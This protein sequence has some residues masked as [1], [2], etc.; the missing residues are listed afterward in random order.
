MDINVYEKFDHEC[1]VPSGTD[2]QVVSLAGVTKPK[3]I[4]VISE[5][6][7]S[8]VTMKMEADEI[9]CDPIGIISLSSGMEWGLGEL[10]LTFSCGNDN[11]QRIRIYAFE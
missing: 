5:N 9:G 2:T 3:M 1:Y 7:G 10:Q 11:S 4:V 8:L 6:P